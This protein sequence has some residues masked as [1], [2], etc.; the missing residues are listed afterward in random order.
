MSLT[1]R[2]ILLIDDLPSI[3]EDYKKI[4]GTS[5]SEATVELD[6]ARSAFLGAGGLAEEQVNEPDSLDGYVIDSAY[7]GQDGLELVKQAIEEGNP[8]AVSY[9]HLTLPTICSV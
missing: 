9:T 1:N 7:Q 2:R 4:L 5:R 3:H 6:A 8:Y